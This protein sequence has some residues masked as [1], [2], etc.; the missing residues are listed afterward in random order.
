MA[1]YELKIHKRGA[2]PRSE[3]IRKMREKNRTK[4]VSVS[5]SDLH[6]KLES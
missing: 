3:V 5:K 2:R 6:S 4:N 1:V